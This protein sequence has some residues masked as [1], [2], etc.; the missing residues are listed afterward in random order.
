MIFEYHLGCFCYTYLATPKLADY[1][2][3]AQTVNRDKNHT[4]LITCTR[5]RWGM[6]LIYG[7]PVLRSKVRNARYK[8]T[9]WTFWVYSP[10]FLEKKSELWDTNSQLQ[11]KKI[12]DAP[13]DRPWS[14]SADFSHDRPGSTIPFKKS[15]TAYMNT[16]NNTCR[17]L[18]I[19][20]RQ[21]SDVTR[22][23]SS[24]R[25]P[26]LSER[27]CWFISFIKYHWAK[28]WLCWSTI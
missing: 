1:R 17:I 14:E 28:V 24:F 25:Q 23:V 10:Q 3:L 2:Q 13:I 21:V 5:Y 11:D 22:F 20:S 4:A 6:E 19:I 7:S 26:S 12:R 8:H 9:I 16:L 18:P 27:P 15:F